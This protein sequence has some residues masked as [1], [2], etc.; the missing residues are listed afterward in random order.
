MPLLNESIEEEKQPA[1]TGIAPTSS[2]KKSTK[3]NDQTPQTDSK[4]KAQTVT[5]SAGPSP[6]TQT[7]EQPEQPLVAE[8]PPP[9]APPKKKKKKEPVAPAEPAASNAP[10]AVDDNNDKQQS[11]T[12]L[13]PPQRHDSV[14]PENMPVV[15]AH[16]DVPD[17]NM[18]A[19]NYNPAQDHTNMEGEAEVDILAPSGNTATNFALA[20]DD[21]SQD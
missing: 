15:S 16:A 4:S 17:A 3:A 19:A 9:V 18:P 2:K 6:A 14:P 1:E 8:M 5:A 7:I 21:A 12:Q 20:E 11:Q 10:P 13:E